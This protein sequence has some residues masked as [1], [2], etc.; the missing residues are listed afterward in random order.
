VGEYKRVGNMGNRTLFIKVEGQISKVVVD[1]VR[2]KERKGTKK[3]TTKWGMV[4]NKI[5]KK[6]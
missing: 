4:Q 3:K 2:E 6:E 5:T 1:G